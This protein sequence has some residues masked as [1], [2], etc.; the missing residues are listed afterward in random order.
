V[1]AI[2]AAILDGLLGAP[3]PDALQWDA[4]TYILTGTGRRQ[5]DADERT[6][7][8]VLAPRFPLLR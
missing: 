4:T 1:A 8:G 5:L 7:L 3:L 2:I 6:T